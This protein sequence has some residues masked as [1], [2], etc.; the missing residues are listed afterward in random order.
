MEV[1]DS[2]EN[3]IRTFFKKKTIYHYIVLLF[4]C[5]SEHREFTF[6]SNAEASCVKNLAGEHLGSPQSFIEHKTYLPFFLRHQLVLAASTTVTIHTSAR[7]FVYAN[8][9]LQSMQSICVE[10]TIDYEYADS[11][12]LVSPRDV[13]IYLNQGHRSSSETRVNRGIIKNLKTTPVC[14]SLTRSRESIG[15][16]CFTNM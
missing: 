12:F 2:I 15:G 9:T 3:E 8:S 13:A 1:I 5:W 4:S 11:R 10:D 16:I 7:Q 14:R 6:F